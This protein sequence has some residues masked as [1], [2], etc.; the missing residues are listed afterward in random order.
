MD[1]VMVFLTPFLFPFFIP[2]DRPLVV[3]SSVGVGSLYRKEEGLKCF[4]TNH[5][6]AFT[7]QC[8][9]GF[10]VP[11]GTSPAS[12]PPRTH[13][14]LD[15]WRL[16]SCSTP[17]PVLCYR[18]KTPEMDHLEEVEIVWQHEAW[19]LSGWGREIISKPPWKEE[20]LERN[21]NNWP[22]RHGAQTAAGRKARWC[23]PA[24]SQSKKPVSLL[25]WSLC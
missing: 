12:R 14:A 4:W 18:R 23:R 17:T 9:L 13:S 20:Q 6:A 3:G 25:T 1:W 5:A 19:L 8:K 16:I 11:L 24:H 21:R 15:W 22:Q 10:C 7:P 2:H